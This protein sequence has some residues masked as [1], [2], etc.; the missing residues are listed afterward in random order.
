MY[1]VV[2]RRGATHYVD[3]PSA[4]QAIAAVANGIKATLLYP[5]E[6]PSGVSVAKVQ[7]A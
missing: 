6:V 4:P 1:R 3:A 5:W 2:D 7:K